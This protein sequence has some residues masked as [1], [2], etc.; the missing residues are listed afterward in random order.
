M[1]FI[2]NELY[3]ALMARYTIPYAPYIMLLI[4]D[5][6][7]EEDYQ[8]IIK[9]TPL[10][11]HHFKKLYIQKEKHLVIPEDGS[12][13]RDART[14]TTSIP[15]APQPDTSFVP[16]VR[17]LSWFQHTILCMK[18]YVHMEQ[19]MSY[20]RDVR[21]SNTQQKILHHVSGGTNAPPKEHVPGSYADWSTEDHTPWLKIE[22]DLCITDASAQSSGRPDDIFED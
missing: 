20:M 2:F 21:A 3:N 12:F 15:R 14:T 6:L 1:D 17:K 4:K 9:D 22:D 13:M 19:Y 5:T 18:V 16:Q 11:D 10:V 7:P 8:N